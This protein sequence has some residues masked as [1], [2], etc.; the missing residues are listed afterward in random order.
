MVPNNNVKNFYLTLSVKYGSIYNKFKIGTKT[1]DMPKG[2]AHYLEHLMFNMPDRNAFDYFG[3]LGSPVNAFTSFDTTCYE[4][5]ANDKF[6]ENLSYLIKYVYT[7]Y[8]TK[9]LVN[10]DPSLSVFLGRISAIMTVDEKNENIILYGGSA[11]DKE[12]SYINVILI[13]DIMNGIL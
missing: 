4:V 5:F 8:F 10:N 13:K 11:S 7:P 2:I 6:T 9:E 3:D 1:Y 12:W